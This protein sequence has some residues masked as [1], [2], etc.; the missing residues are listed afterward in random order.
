MRSNP[1]YVTHLDR[2]L[3]HTQTLKGEYL[4]VKYRKEITVHHPLIK[5]H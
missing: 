5:Y 2:G 3:G 1:V 4:D